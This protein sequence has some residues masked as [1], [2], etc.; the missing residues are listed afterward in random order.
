MLHLC[1]LDGLLL[2]CQDRYGLRIGGDFIV[3]EP[4]TA[5][6]QVV[7]PCLFYYPEVLLCSYF[8]IKAYEHL[9]SRII[10][11]ACLG[12]ERIHHVRQRVGVCC[13][14]CK[15]GRVVESAHIPS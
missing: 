13:V 15:D 5:D 12:V 9:V 10:R 4:A 11:H 2:A 7:V 1:E 8:R 3:C 6:A 14:S